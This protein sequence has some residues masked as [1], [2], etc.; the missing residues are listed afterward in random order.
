MMNLCFYTE[1]MK[2]DQPFR[3]A[4]TADFEKYRF[5]TKNYPE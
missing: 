4:L 2:K 3:F 1:Q 5:N